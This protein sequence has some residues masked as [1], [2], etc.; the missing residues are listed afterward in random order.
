[1]KETPEKKPTRVFLL[2]TFPHGYIVDNVVHE[3]MFKAT[4]VWKALKGNAAE[5]KVG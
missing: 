1:M 5:E 2:P 3:R 4:E